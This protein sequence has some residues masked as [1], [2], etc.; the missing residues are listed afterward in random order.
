MSD[1]IHTVRHSETG[2]VLYHFEW[3]GTMYC[4]NEREA[5]GVYDDVKEAGV[6]PSCGEE[7]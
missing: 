4:E 6:C 5:A 1:D 2:G 7:L 3:V